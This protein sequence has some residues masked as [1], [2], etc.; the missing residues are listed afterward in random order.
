M[1]TALLVASIAAVAIVSAAARSVGAAPSCPS[2][3]TPAPPAPTPPTPAPTAPPPTTSP[4]VAV[5][6]SDTAV[7]RPIPPGFVGF[8]FEYQAI[9]EY[10]GSNPRAI[11]PVLVQL[12]RNLSPGQSPVLRIGGNSAD[13]TWWPIHAIRCTPGITY[14]LTPSWLATTRALAVKTGGRLVLDL[15]LK[16]DSAAEASAEARAFQTGIGLS[17]IE[18]FEIG[19]EPELYPI[20]PYYYEGPNTFPIFP[21]PRTYHFHAYAQEMTAFSKQVHGTAFAGPATG[22]FAWLTHLG[23]LFAAE[24]GVKIVTYHRYP[25]IKCFT[26]PGDPGYPSIPNLLNPAAARNLLQGAARYIALAH[27]H[28][29]T[30]R[31]DELNSVACKGQ[32]GVSDTF[33]SALWMVDTLF[34]M[35]RS[36]VDGVNIHTLPEANYHPFTFEQVNGRWQAEVMPEYYGILLFT[37]A[38]PPGSR[39]LAVNPPPD[40]DLRVRATR[41]PSGQINVVLINDSLSDSKVVNL[42]PPGGAAKTAVVEPLTAPSAAATDGVTLAGQ[43]FGDETGTGTLNG[44]FQPVHLQPANG[45][46]AVQLPA[47][48]A[49]MVSFAPAAA[50]SQP[51]PHTA[52]LR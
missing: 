19:N 20:T 47:A 22:S 14:T 27:E 23:K 21:R 10:T 11:N 38:A 40:P 46:Y 30:F 48:S 3:T 33:A 5:H 37:R 29:A 17:N 15:N 34:A 26:K 36:G 35:V 1:L 2:T 13:E 6:V 39:L 8:S 18:A 52:A 16:L 24:P 44:S 7:G 32:A 4:P 50:G 9:R 31:V 28:H 45:Q 43:S 42:T 41:T 49:A 25:L 51:H 12:I